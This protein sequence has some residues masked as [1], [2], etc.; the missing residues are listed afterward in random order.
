[1]IGAL[2]LALGDSQRDHI[3]AATG[4]SESDA[5]ALN[6]VAQSPGCSIEW[7]RGAL[8]MTHP[9]AVRA[10]DRLV[11][12]NLVERRPGVDR[13][14]VGL[15]LTTAGEAVWNGVTQAR[16]EWLSAVLDQLAPAEIRQLEPLVERLLAALTPDTAV[17]EHICRLC[18]ERT[19]PQ[20]SCPVTLAADNA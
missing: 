12:R 18:D 6:V 10:V 5:A 4:L 8:S 7:L 16:T 11:E 9:G 19:C 20:T 3:A 13:R 17:A 1:M 14:T 2:G 15:A